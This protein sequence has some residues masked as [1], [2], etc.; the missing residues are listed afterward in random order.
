V[1]VAVVNAEQLLFD[2]GKITAG[3][4]P[5]KG[6]LWTCK[7]PTPH[8]PA[9]SAVALVVAVAAAPWMK[10]TDS[11]WFARQVGVFRLDLTEDSLACCCVSYQCVGM[12]ISNTE[13]LLLIEFP[14]ALL[15][16]RLYLSP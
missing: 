2:G 16:L 11:V 10:T 12:V 9:A 6:T 5:A 3:A 4:C 1:W 8:L 7:V 14:I 13:L 15:I